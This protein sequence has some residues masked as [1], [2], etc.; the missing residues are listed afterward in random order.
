MRNLDE[1]DKRG[2]EPDERYTLDRVELRVR[3]QHLEQSRHDVDLDVAVLE[4]AN[5]LEGSFERVRRER[6]HD[7]MRGM[8][9]NEVR[10]VV[11]LTDQLGV[12]CAVGGRAVAA[13]DEADDLEAVLG[14]LADLAVEELRHV[15]EP[16][17]IT[18][19]T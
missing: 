12:T 13:V 3:S 17:M 19:W 8:G 11:G 18:F 14:M 16:T 1:R 10:K 2:G 6:D 15:P 5:H 9:P 4:L 7:T